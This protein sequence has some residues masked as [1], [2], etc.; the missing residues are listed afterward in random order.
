MLL[1][2]WLICPGN[3]YQ[4]LGDLMGQAQISWYSARLKSQVIYMYVLKR[5]RDPVRQVFFSFLFFSPRVSFQ[6]RLSYGV[7]TAPVSN[8]IRMAASA[9]F[10]A[11]VNFYF[12]FKSQTLAAIPLFGHTKILHTR[13][14]MG[15]AHSEHRFS[16]PSSKLC[17]NWLRHWRGTL[18]RHSVSA[19]RTVWVLIIL[20][21]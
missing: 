19:L 2:P 10:C 16:V 9:L 3:V 5:V 17:Q 4:G 1:S 12:I 20:W 21:K 14:R 8:R 18:Y 6:C 13:V 11:H 15:S 7:R